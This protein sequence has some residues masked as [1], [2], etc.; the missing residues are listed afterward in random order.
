MAL[1]TALD[2]LKEAILLE[3]RG[4]SLYLQVAGAATTPAV[5][6]FFQIMAEEEG[7]HIGILEEQFRSVDRTGA[8][9]TADIALDGGTPSADLVLTPELKDQIAGAG[10][11]AAAISAAILMEERAV[12]FYSGR[13]AAIEDGDE[14][15]LYQW[16]SNWEKGHLR[17]LVQLDREIR[18]A[19]WNDSGF[20]PF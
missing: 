13:A 20:W 19:L 1:S 18:Q 11:E 7:R 12:A 16:L 8:F 10:Y 6:E 2:I 14:R 4:Q 15:K 3:R 5:H 17:F 9:S